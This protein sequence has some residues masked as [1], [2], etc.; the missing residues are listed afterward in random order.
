MSRLILIGAGGHGKVV[1]DIAQA[2]EKW[3]S[4][5]FLDDQFPELTVRR[6]KIWHRWP[7]KLRETFIY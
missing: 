2:M 3:E 1:A 4:I 5:E 7:K 6:Q